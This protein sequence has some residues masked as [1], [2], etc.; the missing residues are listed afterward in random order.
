MATQ[1]PR[2]AEKRT[3][4]TGLTAEGR[5]LDVA[6]VAKPGVCWPPGL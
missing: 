1:G 4:P 6:L 5:S 2:G 3:G